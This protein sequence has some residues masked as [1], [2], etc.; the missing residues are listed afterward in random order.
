MGAAGF[1]P[2]TSAGAVV[3]RRRGIA[4]IVKKL[5][6]RADYGCGT[7]RRR[8]LGGCPSALRRLSIDALGEVSEGRRV[9][10]ARPP[11]RRRGSRWLR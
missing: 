1:E 9:G 4:F 11:D 8:P 10:I 6:R 5:A 3:R 2:A 7:T